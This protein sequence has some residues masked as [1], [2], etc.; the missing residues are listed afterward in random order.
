MTKTQSPR[1]VHILCYW[2]TDTEPTVRY[3]GNM[4][5][6]LSSVL[7]QQPFFTVKLCSNRVICFY[8]LPPS[9]LPPSL[10]EA[11]PLSNCS[12]H[13]LYPPNTPLLLSFS[14]HFPH[15]PS[16]YPF[17]PSLPMCWRSGSVRSWRDLCPLAS[18]RQCP[19][20]VIMMDGVI[21]RGAF[22]QEGWA[23]HAFSQL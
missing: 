16:L 17:L 5:L 12:F 4:F 3:W 21:S 19:V 14:F 22:R 13:F 23:H 11:F 18:V 10:P 6:F 7:W 20:G 2:F 8:F 9:F 1:P 15:V